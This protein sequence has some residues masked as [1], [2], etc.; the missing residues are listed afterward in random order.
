ME[1]SNEQTSRQNHEFILKFGIA[2]ILTPDTEPESEEYD[3]FWVNAVSI[4]AA[5]RKA[6]EE[7]KKYR[8]MSHVISAE[9]NPPK[10]S[11]IEV[12]ADGLSYYVK[13]IY[14]AL[15]G[16]LDQYA[17]VFLT[18]GKY[19][20]SEMFGEDNDGNTDSDD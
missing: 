3:R 19:E 7:M 9:S 5:K 15:L 13:R 11:A 4:D 20:N 8:G 12:T 2:K 14:K 6:V 17:Y 1:N 10:W 18:W 16:P